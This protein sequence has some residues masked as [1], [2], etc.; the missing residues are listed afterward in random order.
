METVDAEIKI[1]VRSQ[2]ARG[3]ENRA[4]M[5]FIKWTAEGIFKGVRLSAASIKI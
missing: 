1:F 3:A 4:E 2:R 5:Q